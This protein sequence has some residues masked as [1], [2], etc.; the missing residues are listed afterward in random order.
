MD[1]FKIVLTTGFLAATVRMA[2]PLIFGTIGELIGELSGVMNLGIEGIMTMGAMVGWFVAYNGY[3]LW[4]AVLC[5]AVVGSLIGLLHAVFAVHLGV[6]QQVSGIAITLLATSLSYFL[7]MMALPKGMMPPKIMPFEPI[8]IP[9][10][11][12]IPV[13]GPALFSQTALGYIAITIVPVVIYILFRTPL[14][15]ALRMAGQS[16]LALEG[17]G[18]SVYWVRTGAV[19]FGSALMGVAGAFFALAAFDSFVFGMIGGRG[20]VCIAL[21]FFASWKPGRA[22]FGALMFAA[23]DALQLRIQQEASPVIPY[24]LFLALPYILSIIAMVVIARGLRYPKALF[25]PFRRGER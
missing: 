6:S 3:D 2:T 9:V 21:V 25:L 8:L 7:T 17:Q 15:L 23:F 4:T 20:W 1:V 16:P 13:L 14:G 19:M 5:A 10:L 24:Q 11:S 12:S 18:I 22:L